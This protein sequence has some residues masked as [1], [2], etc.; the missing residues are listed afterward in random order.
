MEHQ[1][2]D[3]RGVLN[4]LGR[5]A[6][7]I[8]LAF[9]VC[10]SAGVTIA[11][12]LPSLYTGSALVLVDWNRAPIDPERPAASAASEAWRVDSEK[13][14]LGSDAVLMAVVD[15]LGLIADAEFGTPDGDG[16]DTDARRQ[17]SLAALKK[18]LRIEREAMTYL[19]AVSVSARDPQKAAKLANAVAG[20][21]V[22]LQHQ[23][24][25]ARAEEAAEAIGARIRTAKEALDAARAELTALL[26]AREGQR[27]AD[28]VPDVRALLA[29]ERLAAVD[30]LG[31]EGADPAALPP[32][33]AELP[34]AQSEALADLR[35]GLDIAAGHYQ[36]LL[37]RGA[38]LAVGAEVQL[39]DSRI[40]SPALVPATP[41]AP[42]RGAI[43]LVAALA[44][45]MAGVGLAFVNDNF[46]GGFTSPA[47]LASV[48][49]RPVLAD[50]PAQRGGDDRVADAVVVAPL[51]PYAEAV[52][53]MRAGIDQALRRARPEQAGE[54][55]GAVIM[56]TSTQAGEGKTATALA[57][58][59]TYALSGKKTLV[60]DGDL[61]DPQ[62]HALLGLGP[63]A[64]L[65]DYLSQGRGAEALASILVTDPASAMSV[66]VGARPSDIPTDQLLA[67]ADFGRLVAAAR[68]NF[69]IVILD[70][71]AIGPLVDGLHLAAVADA[72]VLV[73]KWSATAQSAVR[74]ALERI[75]EASRPATPVLTVLNRAGPRRGR[76]RRVEQESGQTRVIGRG[77][78][79]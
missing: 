76:A 38:E 4:L 60:I 17:A 44:G 77:A 79:R 23:A 27:P 40:V 73:V 65:L 3:I 32:V 28:A 2:A 1:P 72:V 13:L 48:G 69:D 68:D 52:R 36:S 75:G 30:P 59:R 12:V 9:M 37:A 18:A 21:Y 58:G 35:Q 63:E 10:V 14:I 7:L 71:P 43:V 55:A 6:R 29:G 46:V 47:Q 53:R 31:G 39:A 5:Q 56:V 26:A 33:G 62:L 34:G 22:A 51:S 15:G 61:R 74:D 78:T 16:R 54:G 8:A 24:K 57:L 64:G 50:L 45:L 66:I 25:I 67:G 41:S 11:A 19:L 20:T 42:D 70:T 49:G